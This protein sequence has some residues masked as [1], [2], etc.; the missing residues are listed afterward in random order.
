MVIGDFSCVQKLWQECE[1]SAESEDSY[2]EIGA[3]L[4]S[5]QSTGFVVEQNE[6]IV[7]AVLCGSDGRYGYIHHLCVSNT[8]RRQGIGKCLVEECLHFLQRRHV[9]IMVRNTNEAAK[10]FWNQM[11]FQNADWLKV[12]Y[13]ETV[14]G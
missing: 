12:Q 5:P 11:Y 8:M 14:L 2:D 1:L 3:F 10:V 9:V 6:N 4:K 13:C 7:G